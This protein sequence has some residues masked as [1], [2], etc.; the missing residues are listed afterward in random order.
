L[1]KFII[2]LAVF[3]MGT[4]PES[5]AQ[6][7]KAGRTALQFLKIG[8]GARPTALGEAVIANMDG[9]NSIYWNPAALTSIENIEAGFN[10]TSWIGD[11]NIMA[12][13]VGINIDGVGVLAFNYLGLDYGAL[14]EAFTTSASGNTDTRTGN[15]F[16]GSDLAVGFGFARKF[17]D[18][19]SI[20]V[21]AK[22]IREE[23]Y[24]YSSSVWA[25][26]A[27]S[28]YDTG[29]RGV[30]LAMSAQNF[31][32]QVRW[33]D[34]K[35][36]EQ[37]SY[38]IPIVYRIGWSID[39]LGGHNLFLGGDPTQHKL[40]FNMDAVHTNDYAERLHMGLEY[41]AFNMLSLRGGY[42]LNYDEG[43]LSAGVG[44][45]YDTGYLDF[46][47]D[48]SYVVY[49]FLESPHRFSVLLAF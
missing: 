31:S 32:S 29:W 3:L 44:I 4:N 30:R 12:G 9:V 10:Y 26:D 35:E 13:A 11:L 48:Y 22:Y 46:V 25:F 24:T 2:F 7:N 40:T 20:G 34:T 15:T 16:T 27:G 17:T 14:Q 47:F 49:D 28:F 19:L 38:E 18:K 45:N 21:N 23:L 37:Q 41:T 5:F 36:E 43:N 39:L 1:K 6:F 8:V 33:L 42:R